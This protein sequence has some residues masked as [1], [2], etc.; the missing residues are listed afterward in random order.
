M[1][2]SLRK[3]E[4]EEEDAGIFELYRDA[5]QVKTKVKIPDS[6]P[7][8]IS[9]L[10]MAHRSRGATRTRRRTP[11]PSQSALP[12]ASADITDDPDLE[13]RGEE[14]NADADPT[15]RLFHA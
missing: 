9:N 11:L 6:G 13:L 15:R 1:P 14:D 10:S 5:K 12:S 2:Q 4:M 3:S 8:S 7:T